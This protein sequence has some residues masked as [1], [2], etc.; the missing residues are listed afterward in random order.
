MTYNG[1]SLS[2]VGS[3]THN[4]ARVEIWSLVAPDTGT[5]DVVVNLSGSNHG[6]VTVGSMTFTGVDQSTPLGTLATR[7]SGMITN[8]A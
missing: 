6:G 2:S 4:N 7:F 1:A 8:S 5:H 3:Y